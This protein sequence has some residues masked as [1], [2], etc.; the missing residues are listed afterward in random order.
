MR[1]HLWRLRA[2]QGARSG[3]F[4]KVLLSARVALSV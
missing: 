4:A 2:V 1:A 3:G